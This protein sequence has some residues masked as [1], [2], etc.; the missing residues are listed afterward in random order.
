M[1]IATSEAGT[2]ASC[3][4]RVLLVAFW[5][6]A[7]GTGIAGAAEQK[8][9]VVEFR[10]VPFSHIDL[11]WFGTPKE[12]DSR[13]SQIL[14]DASEKA[15]ADPD[16]RFLIDA[17]YPLERY[18]ALHPER[19]P[20]LK[21][22]VAKGQLEINPQWAMPH[23]DDTIGEGNVRNILY[24]KRFVRESFGVDPNVVAYT[25]LPEWMVQT[26]QILRGAGIEFLVMTRLGP[27]GVPLLWW[28]GLDGSRILTGSFGYGGI[29]LLAHGI[30]VDAAT[31]K[32]AGFA[33]FAKKAAAPF[34][35]SPAVSTLGSDLFLPVKNLERNVRQWNAQSEDV[36]IRLSTFGEYFE[37]V[38]ARADLPVVSGEV[39]DGW[40][41]YK[42][43]IFAKTFQ[44]EQTASNL[45]LTAEK[46]ATFSHLAGGRVYPGA[47]IAEAWKWLVRAADH[48]YVG[49]GGRESDEIKVKLR[50]RAMWA[51][52]DIID[53]SVAFIGERV[54]TPR[55]PC[56]PIVVFNP[57]SWRRTDLVTAHVT[58]YPEVE[59]LRNLNWAAYPGTAAAAARHKAMLEVA[60]TWPIP[61]T[62]KMILEDADGKQI[63]FQAA[64]AGREAA[65]GEAYLVFLAEDVPPLGYKTYYLRPAKEQRRPGGSVK[66]AEGVLE[67]EH[68]RVSV[69]RASGA[70]SL[71][72]KASG[73]T[74][75]DGLSVA[76][77]KYSNEAAYRAGKPLPIPLKLDRWEIVENGPVRARLRLIYETGHPAIRAL[78]TEL[79]LTRQNKL[80]IE[81][82]INYDDADVRDIVVVGQSFP[83]SL[84]N[85]Q[86]HYGTPY[87]HNAM[88]DLRA[89][90]L[91]E[92]SAVN[93]AAF[94]PLDVFKISRIA[95]QWLDAGG[96]GGG[97]T[98][99]S[100]RRMF[101][102]AGND[103]R[104]VLF[105]T[106]PNVPQRA[107]S[108]RSGK[109]VSRFA[110]VPHSG[111][112]REAKT[113]R[114]GWD[115]NTPLIS[116]T[117]ENA[118]GDRTLPA[119]LSFLSSASDHAVVTVVKKAED[120]DG[121]VVRLFEAEGREGNAALEFFR[122]VRTASVA[123]L[124]EERQSDISLDRVSLRKDEIKTLKL[125]V[126][127]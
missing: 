76:L 107:E 74:V 10:V 67:N 22:L 101:Q 124:L 34:K 13:F 29:P 42:E 113:Y 35:G 104:C 102:V 126:R 64:F 9:A 108:L 94:L 31:M 111:T 103:L 110:V 119:S 45:L 95:Q 63:D 55:Q 40:I 49:I 28:Q 1:R 5:L 66:V 32:V 7:C 62:G 87:G 121:I 58:L 98:I 114:S 39:P 69:D 37:K 21:Q 51:A 125:L 18:M 89:G 54:K 115:L 117:I 82:A 36:K 120:G 97:F 81:T 83:V 118:T 48:N 57:L 86:F 127:E 84:K 61:K 16:Y 43:T 73:K 59:S 75:L 99:A 46:L 91:E 4:S 93:E 56:L 116:Y 12:V 26:P 44:D 92:Y 122:P 24:A 52:Q 25:D 77:A 15:K 41:G 17:V 23:T 38:R 11:S 68:L 80:D 96:E 109:I 50:E 78:S 33:E 123:N 47:A 14:T 72:D 65:K 2:R 112:W 70:F 20:L 53:S 27:R 30:S 79:M 90:L 85:P 100:N 71:Q 3:F 6:S 60:D 88:T 105:G 8:P 106:S 19:T